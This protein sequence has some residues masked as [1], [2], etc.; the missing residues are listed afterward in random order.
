MPS[1]KITSIF[2]LPP[3]DIHPNTIENVVAPFHSL[4]YIQ[5]NT[6]LIYHQDFDSPLR[7]VYGG[8]GE[9]EKKKC[10]IQRHGVW[11]AYNTHFRS[12]CHAYRPA[13]A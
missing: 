5:P 6:L 8:S 13:S 12:L 4:F 11:A 9:R 1:P 7:S 2:V 10:Q 3:R